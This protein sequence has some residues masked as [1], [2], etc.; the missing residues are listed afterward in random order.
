MIGDDARS[1]DERR[2]A[3]RLLLMR[4]LLHVDRDPDGH[5]LVRRH[6]DWL[7]EWFSAETGWSLHVG[8]TVARLR[9]VPATS[10]DT[11]RP[12]RARSGDAPFSRRRYVI[13]CLALAYLESTERQ[14]TL[15]HVADG[16]VA[17]VAADPALGEAGITFTLTGRD[18]RRDLVAVIRLLL[19][20]SVLRRV[21][22]SEHA[23]VEGTGDALYTVDRAALAAFLAARNPPSMIAATDLDGQ[24]EALTAEPVPDT[25]DAR[26]RS[27]RHHLTRRLVD[28]AVTYHAD[29]SGP[30]RDYLT[31]QRHRMVASVAHATGLVPELR[32][33]GLAMVDERGDC[34]DVKMPDQGTD[35]HLT[36]LVAEHLAERLRQ[37]T[38]N[39]DAGMAVVP[40][41]EL[42]TRVAALAR[43]HAGHWRGDTRAPG[44]EVGLVAETL[45][46]LAALGLVRRVSGGVA[47]LPAIARY[48]LEEPISPAPNLFEDATP[49]GATR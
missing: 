28:D 18:E 10:D 20:W 2:R 13:A 15:G 32:A 45:D 16:I 37:A 12:A 40:L 30:Q 23:Y 31:R 1:D 39:A 36:L 8:R 4:P 49:T 9:K 42:Q 46:R 47:P 33:E 38:A 29:L 5:R 34:T 21:D 48:R 44:A 19:E 14:T 26:N 43:E 35:G 41:A 3:V 11:T 24:V 22:G 25:D 7:R 17:A 6:A 27:L